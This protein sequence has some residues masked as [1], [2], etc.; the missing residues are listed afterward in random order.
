MNL[1]INRTFDVK[2][3]GT[4]VLT[5]LPALS[6]PAS[7]EIVAF[8][9]IPATKAYQVIFDGVFAVKEQDI[10]VNTADATETYQVR[11]VQ[12]FDTVRLA[13][14]EATVEKVWGS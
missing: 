2:R 11:G 9:E 1:P 14:T 7:P 10:L 5:D 6:L 8:F 12:T 4:T 3:G 13:H